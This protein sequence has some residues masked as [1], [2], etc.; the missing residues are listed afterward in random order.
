MRNDLEEQ[1]IAL[2]VWVEELVLQQEGRDSTLLGAQNRYK[3]LDFL[4]CKIAAVSR[5]REVHIP[6]SVLVVLSIWLE[7]FVEVEEALTNRKVPLLR[8][9]PF[10]NGCIE[11]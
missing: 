7:H 6:P 9:C 10:L 8:D 3:I 5:R 4:H 11:S 2:Q 1:S